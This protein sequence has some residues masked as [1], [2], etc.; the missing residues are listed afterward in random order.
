MILQTTLD[1][2]KENLVAFVWLLPLIPSLAIFVLFLCYGNF[3][4][5]LLLVMLFWAVLWGCIYRRTQTK[6]CFEGEKITLWLKGKTYCVSVK[7]ILYIEES[8][9]LGNPHKLHTYKIYMKSNINI[10]VAYLY[11][12][13]RKI[14]KDFRSLFS[15]VPVKRHVVLE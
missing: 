4:W 7:D 10:P 11:A 8:S 3:L 9:F 6:I 15:G 14:Q 1:P 12:R 2:E 5:G 13:N